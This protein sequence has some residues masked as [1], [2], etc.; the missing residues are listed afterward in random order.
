MLVKNWKADLMEIKRKIFISSTAKLVQ[1]KE[2]FLRKEQPKSI[3]SNYQQKTTIR[4]LLNFFIMM[5]VLTL[6]SRI[7]NSLTIAQVTTDTIKSGFLT[8]RY[9]I[10]G[11]VETQ[12]TLDIVLP[13]GL[14]I[15]N[16]MVEVGDRINAGDKI[17]QLDLNGIQTIIEQLENE[18]YLLDMKITNLSNGISSVNT[19]QIQRAENN[20]KYAKEDYEHLLNNLEISNHRAE[21]DLAE[22]Q[23]K[24]EEALAT[25]ENAKI[26]TK[27]LLIETAK[28]NLAIANKSLTDAEYNRIEAIKI[29]ENTLESMEEALSLAED[30]Y[31]NAISA[32]RRAKS[33]LQDAEE[34]LSSLNEDATEEERIAAQNA[35]DLAR[36][37]VTIAQNQTDIAASGLSEGAVKRAY[38]DLERV[39]IRQ[40]QLVL[41][42][43]N[44]VKK[45][46]DELTNAKNQSDF[47]N[48]TLVIAAQTMV[49][50]AETNLKIITRNYEDSNLSFEE[51]S[52]QSQRNIELAET[53]LNSA[54][55]LVEQEKLLDEATCKQNEVEKLQYNNEKNIKQDL[56]DQMNDLYTQNGTITAPIAGTIKAIST[57]SITQNN[58]AVLTLF[59]TDQGFQFTAKVEQKTAEQLSVGDIGAFTYINGGISQSIPMQISS[60]GTS[61]EDGQVRISAQLTKDKLLNKV[62][63]TLEIEKS[64]DR[65]QMVL[66]IS[67]LRIVGG[68][69]V[70]FVVCETQSIIGTEQ[71]VEEIDI[72]IKDQDSENMAIEGILFPDDSI[73]VGASKPI[74]KGDRIRVED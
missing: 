57:T 19:E 35:I 62:T 46:E 63:G 66:P 47:S 54:K 55:K 18:I 45:A 60:I 20:L 61:N 6:L 49:D 16:I 59:R 69:A 8:Q 38:D 1:E 53:E 9:T 5:L 73:V 70:V 2:L 24:Y 12:D 17:L 56:L 52:F 39:K 72:T 21:E 23:I 11:T 29:A 36:S 34:Y 15:S 42:A 67:A 32:L 3:F 27:E 64:S 26:T 22:A 10:P 44:I 50:S 25:L 41:E 58:E 74:K 28:N 14:R 43:E 71:I 30:T 48:E 4:L 65:Y 40:N 37:E 13:S 31:S 51:Q 7:A 33:N 68:K